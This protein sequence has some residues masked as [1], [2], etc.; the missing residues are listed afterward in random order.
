[1]ISDEIS[2]IT[3]PRTLIWRLRDSLTYQHFLIAPHSAHL[4]N[5]YMIVSLGLKENDFINKFAQKSYYVKV[6]SNMQ[7]IYLS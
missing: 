4:Q 6:T 7:Q 5:D 3:Y 2:K 1:M